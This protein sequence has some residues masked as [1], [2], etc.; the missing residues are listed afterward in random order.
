MLTMGQ[1]SMIDAV[2]Y[3][4]D[5]VGPSAISIW[6]WASARFDVDRF[7]AMRRDGRVISGLLMIDQSFRVKGG[8][9]RVPILNAWSDA[10][11]HRSIRYLRTHAKMATIEG[12]G[13]K[14][15]VRGSLNLN[16][17]DRWENLDISEGGEPFDLVRA[18]ELSFPFCE[19]DA[20]AH[21]I[22]AASGLGKAAKLDAFRG[23]TSWK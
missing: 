3:C 9:E 22:Y 11:G 21:E 4:I 23:L 19:I 20:P 6:C 15:L 14:L 13:C 2:S 18:Q 17:N 1:F 12:G 10:F 8:G 16:H 7:A 5:Q